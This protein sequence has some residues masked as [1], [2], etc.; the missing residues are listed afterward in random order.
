MFKTNNRFAY[1]ISLVRGGVYAPPDEE[2]VQARMLER[3]ELSRSDAE[4]ELLLERF[5]HSLLLALGEEGAKIESVLLEG[6]RLH[7][8]LRA[9]I[10][11][12]EADRLVREHAGKLGFNYVKLPEMT[13]L[14]P[15]NKPGPGTTFH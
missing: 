5:V 8:I 7:V 13:V 15:I 4:A 3:S 10:A 14:H 9:S 6:D 2:E 12:D 1:D 11:E